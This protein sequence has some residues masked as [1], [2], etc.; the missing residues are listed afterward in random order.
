MEERRGKFGLVGNLGI[1]VFWERN[2]LEGDRPTGR[3]LAAEGSKVERVKRRRVRKTRRAQMEIVDWALER[4][5]LLELVLLKTVHVLEEEEEEGVEDDGEEVE[6]EEKSLVVLSR[7]A[8]VVPPLSSGKNT[9][10]KPIPQ[11]SLLLLLLL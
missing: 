4:I 7:M 6:E 9:R 1:W 3:G 2:L 11:F 5:R 8:V 10:S